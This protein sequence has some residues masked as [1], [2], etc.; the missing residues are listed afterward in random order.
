ML[1]TLC[2]D[3]E[4]NGAG[5]TSLG[6]CKGSLHRTDGLRLSAAR[7]IQPARDRI[8]TTEVPDRWWFV[9]AMRAA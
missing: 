4:A 5:A 6:T 2:L 7:G 1:G 8:T 3:P 9:V